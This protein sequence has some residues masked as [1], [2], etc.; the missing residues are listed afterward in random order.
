MMGE[1]RPQIG[2]TVIGISVGM[3]RVMEEAHWNQETEELG[4][5]R[6][7]FSFIYGDTAYNRTHTIRVNDGVGRNCF[8]Y[9]PFS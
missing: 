5:P 4:R 9:P 2:G 8:P 3:S 1:G 7:I 6:L